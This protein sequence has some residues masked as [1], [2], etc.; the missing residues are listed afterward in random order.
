MCVNS[1]IRMYLGR[2]SIIVLGLD[3]IRHESAIVPDAQDVL[4][5]SAEET[6]NRHRYHYPTE[7]SKQMGRTNR[8]GEWG[9]LTLLLMLIGRLLL[10]L[11]GPNLRKEYRGFD[12]S[13]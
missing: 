1:L 12:S 11:I 6:P 2:S 10:P 5:F 8:R 4:S 13:C 7:N 3:H 9:E